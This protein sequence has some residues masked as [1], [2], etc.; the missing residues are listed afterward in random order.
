MMMMIAMSLNPN[1]K[2]IYLS[3]NRD[4][5]SEETRIGSE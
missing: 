1:W 2:S 3:T 5:L 4:L